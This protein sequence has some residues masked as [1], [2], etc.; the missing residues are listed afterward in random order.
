MVDA[1]ITISTINKTARREFTGELAQLKS[2]F[3]HGLIE[4][5]IWFACLQW[6]LYPD[7]HE[8]QLQM[9]CDNTKKSLIKLGVL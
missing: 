7:Y 1:M 9:M 2:D 4:V 5:R 3:E 6:F 8:L